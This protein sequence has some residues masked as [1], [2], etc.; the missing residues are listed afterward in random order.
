MQAPLAR[1][2]LQ[3]K[4]APTPPKKGKIA[5]EDP[6]K[7][8]SIPGWKCLEPVGSGTTADVWRAENRAG[9]IAAIKIA[10]APA[11][12]QIVRREALQL[13]EVARRWGAKILDTGAA[14][15][16]NAFFLATE[17]IDGARL[18]PKKIAAD[19]RERTAAI[20]VHGVARALAELHE[21]G[22]RHGD[23]KP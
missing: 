21:A 5:G 22:V 23:V 17:W 20:V 13:H 8:P 12:I 19:K 2:K 7:S 3:P 4:L 10:T 15:D 9:V 16:G 6:P 14:H 11:E 1:P 18:D